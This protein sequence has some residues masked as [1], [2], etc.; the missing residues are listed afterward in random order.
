MRTAFAVLLLSCGMA[1]AQGD[2]RPIKVGDVHVVTVTDN[3]THQ[4]YDE[5]IT[6]VSEQGGVFRTTHLRSDTKSTREGAYTP[7]WDVIRSGASGSV[8]DPPARQF[9]LPLQVGASW[10]QAS[11]ITV[12]SGA[13]SRFSSKSTVTGKEKLSTPAGEFDAFRMENKGYI[14]GVSWP[15]GFAYRQVIWYAPSI[16]RVL[17]EE[18]KEMRPMGTDY[19][20]ELKSFTPAN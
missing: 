13:R 10:E 15:G 16:N 8:F 20:R 9:Q 11:A 14:N 2:I 19:V 12:A 17:R 1:F 3:T 5:T 7:S 4:T 18:Y 6:V